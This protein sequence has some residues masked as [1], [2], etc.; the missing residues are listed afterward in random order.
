MNLLLDLPFS[1]KTLQ[2]ACVVTHSSLVLLAVSEPEWWSARKSHT[3]LSRRM[4]KVFAKMDVLA[5]HWQNG[6]QVV[7]NYSHRSD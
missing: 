2:N 5:N 3:R 1:G 7:S 4:S 6:H